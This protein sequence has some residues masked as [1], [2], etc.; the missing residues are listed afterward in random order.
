M[1]ELALTAESAFRYLNSRIFNHQHAIVFESV[2]F[3]A[4]LANRT[5]YLSLTERKVVSA[6]KRRLFFQHCVI[7]SILENH[8]PKDQHSI[9]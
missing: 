5:L 9:I 8:L 2:F 6:K 7:H 3:P 1:S 4:G